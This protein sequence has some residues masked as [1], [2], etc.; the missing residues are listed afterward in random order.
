MRENSEIKRG[1]NVI[2]GKVTYKAVAEA[3]GLEYTPI[4][5]LL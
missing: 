4:D 2:K 3:F 1:A 5:G